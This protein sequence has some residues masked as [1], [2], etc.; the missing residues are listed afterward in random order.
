MMVMMMILYGPDKK[1]TTAKLK[2]VLRS[3]IVL[4]RKHRRNATRDVVLVIFQL[5]SDF[6]KIT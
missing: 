6:Q 3:M 1:T 2:F 5:Y 4:V